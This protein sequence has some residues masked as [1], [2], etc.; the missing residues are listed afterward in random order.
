MMQS[1]LQL[2]HKRE[3][4]S[5]QRAN[6]E[7][8][9]RSRAS[10]HNGICALISFV[11]HCY[12]RHMAA[13]DA[14]EPDCRR[15]STAAACTNGQQDHDISATLKLCKLVLKCAQNSVSFVSEG[16]WQLLLDLLRDV[17][18]RLL[19]YISHPST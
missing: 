6:F 10:L 18:P 19:P 7:M 4:R 15:T 5:R 14:A 9:Q 12:E 2:L 3:L 8:Q 1:R 17:V 16:K 13:G 11:Q